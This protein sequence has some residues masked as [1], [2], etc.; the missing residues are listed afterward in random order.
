MRENSRKIRFHISISEDVLDFL[1]LQALKS[2]QCK[3]E[4]IEKAVKKADAE[5]FAAF[6]R[7]AKRSIF[8]RK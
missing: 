4:L 3:S 8:A 7:P 1:E 2:G 5:Q 6:Q